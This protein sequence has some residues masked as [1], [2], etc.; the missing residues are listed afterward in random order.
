L[1][2]LLR[3]AECSAG[4][5]GAKALPDGCQD[6]PA[7]EVAAQV[8]H[9]SDAGLSAPS[10][11]D[12]SDGVRPDATADADL[13]HPELADA[14]AGKLAD[15]GQVCP[16]WAFRQWDALLPALQ[17]VQAVEQDAEAEPYIPDEGQS[18][19]RSCAALAVAEVPPQPALRDVL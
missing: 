18:A 3:R 11:S 16:A 5:D 13:Q 17:H 9:R 6:E 19:E 7:P 12:A 1:G 14:D 15:P 8:L 2:L 10:A 4:Q